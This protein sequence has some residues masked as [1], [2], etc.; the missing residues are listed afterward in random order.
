MRRCGSEE[1]L[2]PARTQGTQSLQSLSRRKVISVV[3]QKSTE[4]EPCSKRVKKANFSDKES[5]TLLQEVQRRYPLLTQVVKTS[6]ISQKKRAAWHE[7]AEAVNSV[8]GN[9]R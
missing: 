4:M 9:G 1:Q 7:I 5:L 8:G 3:W 6:S 2:V